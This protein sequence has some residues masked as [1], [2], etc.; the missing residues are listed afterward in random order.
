[1]LRSVGSQSSTLFNSFGV[2]VRTNTVE[3]GNGSPEASVLRSIKMR[4]PHFVRTSLNS[5]IEI[6]CISRVCVARL[7]SIPKVGG[8]ETGCIL[9]RNSR[10]AVRPILQRKYIE[11]ANRITSR[12]QRE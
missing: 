9:S 10:F 5:P 11:A 8:C 3:I 6:H 7:E 2:T 1:M 12:N 4:S